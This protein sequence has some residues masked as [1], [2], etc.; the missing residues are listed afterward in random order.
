MRLCRPKEVH[1]GLV[2]RGVLGY[3]P[4]SKIHCCILHSPKEEAQGLR[5]FWVLKAT[6]SILAHVSGDMEAARVEGPGAGASEQL[7][8]AGCLDHRVQEVSV[9][10]RT[11]YAAQS[12][13]GQQ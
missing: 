6:Q 12:E 11:P 10:E 7:A 9:W 4:Q 2:V 1:R 3:P 13:S 8:Q 5:P